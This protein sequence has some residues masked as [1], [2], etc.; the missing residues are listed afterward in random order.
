MDFQEADRGYERL[1][2]EYE[3]GTLSAEA[4][5]DELRRMMVQDA[6][7][8]WWAKARESGQWSYHD[9]AAWVAAD[10]PSLSATPSSADPAPVAAPEAPLPE[11][12]TA[13]ETAFL[14]SG[15]VPLTSGASML[16]YVVSFFVPIVGAMVFFV[17]RSKPAA[18]DRRV[19]QFAL[20]ISA[21]SIVLSCGCFLLLVV[22][23][24]G[25]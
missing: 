8:R 13:D 4:F 6:Q 11:V 3:D 20:A 9:G 10:P 2:A 17:Y 12:E 15:E 18:S 25:G 21:F 16:L 1:R 24:S 19:A 22:S 7:G 23:G 14:S 5:D